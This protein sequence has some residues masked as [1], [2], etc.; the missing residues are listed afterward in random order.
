MADV[1]TSLADMVKLNDVSVRDMGVTD[2]FND[3]PSMAF[4]HTIPASHGTDHKFLKEVGAPSVGFRAVNAGIEWSTDSDEL[5]TLALK[6]LDASFGI[7]RTLVDNASRGGSVVMQ[8][9]G[10]RHLRAAFAKAELQM[11]YGKGSADA[12]DAGGFQ[13]LADVLNDTADAMVTAADGTLNLTSVYAIR[14][15]SDESAACTVVGNDGMIDIPEYYPVDLLDGTGKHY[16]GYH[17]PIT[18]FIGYQFGSTRSA[19]RLGNIGSDGTG[20]TDDYLSDLYGLFPSAHKPTFF[21]M[22]ERSRTQLQKSRTTYSPT[23]APAPIPADWNGVPIVVSDNIGV[24]ETALTGTPVA[25][26]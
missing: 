1:L 24:S 12:E 15:V 17:Q 11:L 20:L 10:Q 4:M 7:D 18:G 23:G 19:A 5:V 6:I 2:I 3:A 13:G 26:T 22:G 21:L 9:K 8:R 16:P 25:D 14:S